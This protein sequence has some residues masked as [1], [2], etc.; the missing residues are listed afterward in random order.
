MP[1]GTS[2]SRRSQNAPGE[3]AFAATARLPEGARR[4]SK[5]SCA[6]LYI[7][8]S[9]LLRSPSC[10]RSLRCANCFTRSI[11]RISPRK[12]PRESFPENGSP[13]F[14]PAQSALLEDSALFALP[15][16][17]LFG[18]PLVVLF[19]ALGQRDLDLDLAPAPVHGRWNQRVAL[20]LDL[21]DKSREFVLV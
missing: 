11:R 18:A 10:S 9:A 21:A 20:A 3:T 7:A 17:L 6:N 4:C 12:V 2:D 14:T 1:Q 5:S 15:V 19:L 16:A 8:I 13:E